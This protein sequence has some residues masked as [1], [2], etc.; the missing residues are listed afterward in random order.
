MSTSAMISTS[1]AEE[2]APCKTCEICQFSFGSVVHKPISCPNEEC[3]FQS[4]IS[5]LGKYIFQSSVSA[6]CMK[7]K[8]VFE[9]EYLQKKTNKAFCAKL[10]A[11][12]SKVLLEAERKLLPDTM[13]LVQ[14]ENKK[15]EKLEQA[16]ELMLQIAKLK[17][18]RE[19][20]LIEAR[21]AVLVVI[22]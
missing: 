9:V 20:I 22:F 1:A 17:K 6:R 4:C 5:C 12:E 16:K 18:E 11:H 8:V 15:K 2:A 7:C 21:G 10:K 3:G 19:R 13:I 14:K